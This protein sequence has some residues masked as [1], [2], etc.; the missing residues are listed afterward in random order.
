MRDAATWFGNY[1]QDHQHPTNRL[2]HWICVPAITW[3][4]I[5][6]IWLIPVPSVI[7][8]PGLWAVVAM[9]LA[10]LFYYYRLSRRIGL[11]M[12]LVF[13]ALGVITELLF[14]SLGASGLAWLAVGV[15]VAAWIG[16]FVGHAIEG[17]RPSFFTDLQYLL[18]G[19]AWLMSKAMRRAGF[20][21]ETPKDHA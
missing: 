1:S 20:S 2:I 19:P 5:A 11:A 18:I 9:F 17:R 16:Q 3:C 4:A 7:G 21:Y 8:R 10:F 13:I 15:F 14:R 12:A 6:L